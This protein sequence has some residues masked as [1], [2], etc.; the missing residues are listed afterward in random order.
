MNYIEE[1]CDYVEAL[2]DAAYRNDMFDENGKSEFV[3]IF[4]DYI[5][6]DTDILE[7]RV[8]GIVLKIKLKNLP[9]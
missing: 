8:R 1:D 4:V 9:R 2:L 7:S 6:L 5:T 3:F